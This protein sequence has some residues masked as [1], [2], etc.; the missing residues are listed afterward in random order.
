[1]TCPICSSPMK[2]DK[3]NS[4]I[5]TCT[6][7]PGN[8]QLSSAR[9]GPGLNESKRNPSVPTPKFERLPKLSYSLL[10]ETALR[11]KLAELGIS[12]TGNKPL[13]ERRHT[14]WVTLWN[15]NCDSKNP[16]KKS[17]LLHDLDIWERTQG[18]RVTSASNGL[19]SGQIDLR[20]AGH[21]FF[22]Y[23]AFKNSLLNAVIRRDV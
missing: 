4:H 21:A 7:I 22:L 1:M 23:P 9:S 2:M 14:E 16:R 13:M 20:Y 11:K 19:S 5:D 15:A 17:D 8:N 3:I 12:T 6:G 10:K 18:S